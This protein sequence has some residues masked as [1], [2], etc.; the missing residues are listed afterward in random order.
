MM[1]RWTTGEALRTLNFVMFKAHVC[2][3]VCVCGCVASVVARSMPAAP[4]GVHYKSMRCLF[5][6]LI[7]VPLLSR[8]PSKLPQTTA[9]P[10]NCLLGLLTD[11]LCRM[12]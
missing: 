9:P 8:A 5:S 11:A 10:A 3:C 1:N 7:L 2:L 4:H 6:L 12:E